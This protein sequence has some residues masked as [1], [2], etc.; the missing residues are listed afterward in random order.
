MGH[1]ADQGDDLERRIS[2]LESG[3]TG[4]VTDGRA[5]HAAPEPVPAI[6]PQNPF[7]DPEA[8]RSGAARWLREHW[9][10]LAI[11]ALTVLG[12]V[13]TKLDDVIPALSE[14]APDWVGPVVL[15][16]PVLA[17]AAYFVMRF[18]RNR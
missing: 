12:A 13:L 5:R 15:L 14:P 8:L 6:N 17:V 10:V 4:G 2:E 9:L 7:E 11:G 18:I 1:G 3:R 16:M